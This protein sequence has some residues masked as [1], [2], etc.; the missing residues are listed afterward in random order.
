MAKVPNYLQ[1]IPVDIEGRPLSW[2][3]LSLSNSL[4]T[5]DATTPTTIKSPLS[6]NNSTI[7]ALNIP[8]NAITLIIMPQGST[9]VF[10]SE[11]PTMTHYFS[12]TLASGLMLL[13]VTKMSTI[14][15]KAAATTTASFL[16]GI[17]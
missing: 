4:T 12:I 15:L 17:L 6:L 11:D 8:I 1:A 2:S 14:Y 3:A 5:E 7:V 10:F 9:N 16:F 13:N